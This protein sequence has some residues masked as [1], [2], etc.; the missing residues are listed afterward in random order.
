MANQFKSADE[1]A[2]YLFDVA[3]RKGKVKA[4]QEYERIY[5]SLPKDQQDA[6]LESVNKILNQKNLRDDE[7]LGEAKVQRYR[8]KAAKNMSVDYDKEFAPKSEPKAPSQPTQAPPA[9]PKPVAKEVAKPAP[10]ASTDDDPY[11]EA[12]KARRIKFKEMYAQALFNRD[13]EKGYRP[14]GGSLKP[15]DTTAPQ[16]MSGL[17]GIKADVQPE[18]SRPAIGGSTLKMPAFVPKK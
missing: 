15:K 1:A 16:S 4:K 10:K 5:T 3:I 2:G 13:A 11:A 6:F 7:G 18:N 17:L 14:Y 12:K 9:A 8:E